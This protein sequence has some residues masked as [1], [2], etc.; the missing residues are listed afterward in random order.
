[1]GVA[2]AGK[3]TLAVAIADRLSAVFVEADDL[4]SAEAKAQMAAGIPLTDE[5][6]WP[7][8]GRVAARVRDELAMGHPVV[9]SCSA[10]KRSYREFL[11]RV[12]GTRLAFVHVH[13][14]EAELAERIGHRTGHFMPASMLASQLVTLEPLAAD[15]R[16]IVVPLGLPVDDAAARALEFLRRHA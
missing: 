5:D 10:L 11:T 3:S 15:E 6:R 13:G 1:M 8:L 14:S 7:W 12:S 9:A 2:G 16:G 4:H